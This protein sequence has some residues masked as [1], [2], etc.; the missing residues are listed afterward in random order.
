MKPTNP[1]APAASFA[2]ENEKS[3]APLGNPS[4]STDWIG[5]GLRQLYQRVVDE[6]MPTGFAELLGRLDEGAT[7]PTPDA[8]ARRDESTPTE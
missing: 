3:A 5:D 8:A 1:S 6:P 4:T 2:A 7:K